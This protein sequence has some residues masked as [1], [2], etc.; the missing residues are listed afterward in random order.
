[1]NK[2]MIEKSFDE[3][4]DWIRWKDFYWA[5]VDISDNIKYFIFN[6][7]IPKVLNDLIEWNYYISDVYIKQ[8]AKELYDITLK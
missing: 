8:K 7:I 6:E 3:T 2:E 1:M 4:F 5:D